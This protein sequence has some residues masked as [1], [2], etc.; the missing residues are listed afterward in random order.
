MATTSTKERVREMRF[1]RG[2]KVREIATLLHISTQA[3]YQHL[4]KIQQ[5]SA[6]VVSEERSA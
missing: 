5:E 4:D 2:L 3:V 6:S 1:E